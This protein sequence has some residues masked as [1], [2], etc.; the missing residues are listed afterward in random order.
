VTDGTHTCTVRKAWYR[1]GGWQWDSNVPEG[2]LTVRGKTRRE[3]A[4][5]ALRRLRNNPPAHPSK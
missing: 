4:E 5:K 1:L 2:R 3:C